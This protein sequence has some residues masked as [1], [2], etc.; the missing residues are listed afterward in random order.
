MAI[1]LGDHFS[2]GKLLKFTAPSIAM[3]IFTSIYG[4][5]DGYFVSNFAGKTPFAAVNLIWPYVML[6]GVTGFI[7]GSGG[8]ALVAKTLG[9]GQKHRANYYFSLLVYLAIFV[10]FFLTAIGLIFLEPVARLLGAE[11]ELLEYCV[12]YGRILFVGIVLLVLQYMFQPFMITAEKPRLNLR[13]TFAAGLTNIVLDAVFIGVLGLGIAG[14]AWAT[15]M[16]QAVGALVPFVYFSGKSNTSLLSLGRTGWDGAAVL[17]S[18]SNGLS[19]FFTNISLSIV[20]M[21]YNWQLLRMAGE[22]GVAAY[23][24]IMYMALVFL[25][26]YFGYVMGVSPVISYHYGA[27]NHQEMRNLKNRSFRILAVVSIVMTA[28]SVGFAGPIAALFVG[29]DDAMLELTR[30]AFSLYAFSFLLAPVNIFCSGF[31]TALN[32]GPVSAAIAFSRMLLF[33]CVAV[34]L[35][36]KL[37]GLDGIW[38]AMPVAE[39]AA[40]LVSMYFLLTRKTKYGY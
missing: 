13:I 15:V 3:M 33:Q 5:V 28:L 25:A 2:Y 32:N 37:M 36:P 40:L 17:Q 26:I 38:L 16:G 22:E 12:Q 1:Q 20:S 11:G 8:S 19:E 9:E 24:V 21:L 29:Y 31:F 27:Q 6:F 23:G 39:L 34:L 30:H 10:S 18:C 7:F 14:A 35:L 4:V